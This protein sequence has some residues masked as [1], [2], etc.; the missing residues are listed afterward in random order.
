MYGLGG[1]NL[2]ALLSG[3]YI[4]RFDSSIS[5]TEDFA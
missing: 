3:N 5:L 1:S 4:V 2:L